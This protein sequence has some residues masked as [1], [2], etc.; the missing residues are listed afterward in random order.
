MSIFNKQYNIYLAG[1]MQGLTPRE[2]NLWRTVIVKSLTERAEGKGYKLTFFNPCEHYNFET[3]GYLSDKE[4][5]DYDL[6]ALE[7]SD[8]VIVNCKGVK[9]SN[10]TVMEIFDA[11]NKH[12][13]I[14]AF[15]GTEEDEKHPWIER[16]ITR[17]DNS[18]AD[19]LEYFD[20]FYLI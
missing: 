3:K 6:C 8:I 4:V 11:W 9:T 5:M 10:G 19:M 15:H 2:M 14:L 20:E 13:P 1:K 18:M 17:H 16:C 7:H 12:I